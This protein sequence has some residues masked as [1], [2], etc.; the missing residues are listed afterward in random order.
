MPAATSTATEHAVA[1][2]MTQ[3]GRRFTRPADRPADGPR[4][5]GFGRRGAGAGERGGVGT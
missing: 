3:R 5:R 1:I 2:R 4:P